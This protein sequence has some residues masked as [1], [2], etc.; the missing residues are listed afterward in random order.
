MSKTALGVDC[1][2]YAGIVL[3]MRDAR[4][5]AESLATSA[6][7]FLAILAFLAIGV[8][9]GVVVWLGVTVG[10]AVWL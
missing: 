8:L 2:D 3:A 10:K 4:R 7:I 6:D 1:L 9:G 5:Q